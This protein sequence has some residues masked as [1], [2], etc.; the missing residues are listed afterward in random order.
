MN[1][2]FRLEGQ[3]EP[4]KVNF[5]YVLALL[6]V[7]RKKLKLERTQ[8]DAGVETMTLRWP[9]SGATCQVVNPRL[10]EEETQTLKM[11]KLKSQR[12]LKSITPEQ[13]LEHSYVG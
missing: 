8:L 4:S 5:R 6:L 2:L 7:R 9:R 10:T 11:G 1:G 3:A 12:I 13:A